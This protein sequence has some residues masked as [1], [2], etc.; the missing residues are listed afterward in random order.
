M[1]FGAFWINMMGGVALR[2]LSCIA[3]KVAKKHEPTLN[4]HKYTTPPDYA[5]LDG[6]IKKYLPD[7]IGN[8]RGVYLVQLYGPVTSGSNK[9][10]YLIRMA[11][12]TKSQ[13]LSTSIRKTDEDYKIYKDYE[14]QFAFNFILLER[15]T[16]SVFTVIISVCFYDF[17]ANIEN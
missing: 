2:K 5:Y 4:N 16:N 13:E 15:P 6:W 10:G 14:K 7:E 9:R 12:S 8:P 3:I 11:E 1:Q 17:H